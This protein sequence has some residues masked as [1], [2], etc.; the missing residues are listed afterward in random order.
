MPHVQ[1]TMLEGR[2]LEQK[3]KLVA[4]VTDALAEECGARREAISIAIVEVSK[5]DFASAG[6][7][8]ADKK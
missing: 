7:L 2:T 4:R 1:V 3:R 6:T 5:E 8:V